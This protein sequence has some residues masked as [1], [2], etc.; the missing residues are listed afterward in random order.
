M[1]S[2]KNENNEP[3][4]TVINNAFNIFL[5]NLYNRE[6]QPKTK[7]VSRQKFNVKAGASVMN[8]EENDGLEAEAGVTDAEQNKALAPTDLYTNPE[9][10][11]SKGKETKQVFGRGLR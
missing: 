8:V 10:S 4:N 3:D 11:T 2:S 7:K 6:T 1:P 9:P 5:R